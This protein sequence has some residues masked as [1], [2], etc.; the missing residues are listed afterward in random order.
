M[1]AIDRRRDRFRPNQFIPMT[2]KGA[3]WSW[4]GGCVSVILA[5]LLIVLVFSATPGI[6]IAENENDSNETPPHVH[7][8][9]LEEDGD[10]D[11]LQSLLANEL[12]EQLDRSVRELTEGEY[13]MAR[14]VLGDEYL[15]RLSD[16]GSVDGETDRDGGTETFESV[17]E[18]QEERVALRE[19]F[20]ET[21]EQYEEAVA[22]GD[23][24]EARALARELIELEEKLEENLDEMLEG[25][26][27]IDIE[28]FDLQ[29]AIAA[30]QE[31]QNTTSSTTEEIASREFDETTLTLTVP[32]ETV[33]FLDPLEASGTLALEDGD[34]IANET[35]VLDLGGEE[36]T[37]RTNEDGEFNV[38]HRPITADAGETNLT[39]R[40]APDAGA[41]HLGSEANASI[42]VEQ[43]EATVSMQSVTEPVAFGENFSVVGDVF[44]DGMAVDDGNLSIGLEHEELT[45]FS[46][47]EGSFDETVTVPPTIPA[48]DQTL[49][50]ESVEPDKAVIVT[51]TTEEVT[52]ETTPTILDIEALVDAD[53][54]LLAVSGELRTVDGR[55]LP[56]QT[57]TLSVP[58]ETL[59]TVETAENGSFAAEFTL[60]AS[61]T[62]GEVNVSASFD[63]SGTN[64]GSTEAVDGITIPETGLLEGIPV[65]SVLV[66]IVIVGGIVLVVLARRFETNRWPILRVFHSAESQGMQT[67]SPVES[68]TAV[69]QNTVTP[70]GVNYLDRASDQLADDATD[71]AVVFAYA[72]VRSELGSDEDGSL[73]HWEFF[74]RHHNFDGS[75]GEE[76]LAALTDGFEQVV[77]AGESIAKAEAET[78]IEHARTICESATTNT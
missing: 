10:L 45:N 27:I 28:H 8:D 32:N 17:R 22:D 56:D 7:P 53:E 3:G 6:A 37:T 75:L 58:G 44:V 51:P 36:F 54:E 26:G 35:I 49:R 41:D 50:I 42:T 52:I 2:V 65:G 47:T 40:N 18:Q 23:E 69:T 34:R 71:S 57:V 14:D 48:G 11:A 78:Q 64:L 77:F 73:T 4:K 55:I 24:E 1:K 67:G 12:G 74:N 25:Y 63:G 13:E 38:A 46:I 20:D 76:S 15:E 31:D 16:Y 5:L 68:S 39:V 60:P 21:L 70:E 9:E 66:G 19:E 72:A 59:G 29:E 33:S 61:L 30:L 43:V 62:A